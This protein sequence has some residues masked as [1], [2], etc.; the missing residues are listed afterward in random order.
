[1]LVDQINTDGLQTKFRAYS[2][3]ELSCKQRIGKPL[4][5]ILLIMSQVN[6]ASM[7]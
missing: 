5:L 7:K 6:I 4:G 3:A 1:M 2:A